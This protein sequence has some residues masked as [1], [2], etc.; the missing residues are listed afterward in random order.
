MREPLPVVLVPGLLCSPRLYGGQ[1]PTLWQFGP[2]IIADH[3]RDDTVAAI[4]RRTLAAAPPRFALVGLSMGGVVAFEILRQAAERVA[5]LA[6]LDTTAR[7]DTPEHGERRL[8]QIALAQKGRFAEVP[9]LLFPFFLHPAHHGDE[10]LRQVVRLMAQETGPEAFVRQQMAIMNRP[11]SR[12]S[13][14]TVRCPTLVLVGDQDEITPPVQST[15]IA[16][17][18]ADARLVIVPECGHLSTLDRPQHV[19]HALIEWLDQSQHDDAP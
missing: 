10:A 6:L 16:N 15:E 19:T 3:R 14:A 13:L 8:A 12:P 11:D 1:L 9:D 2:V 7:P 4:A 18:V 17:D 5:L